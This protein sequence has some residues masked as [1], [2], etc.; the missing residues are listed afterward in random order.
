MSFHR[1][2]LIY[3]PTEI[4]APITF[5]FHT[6]IDADKYRKGDRLTFVYGN[7]TFD[8]VVDRWFEDAGSAEMVLNLV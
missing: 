7:S 5:P 1:M 8:V 6:R 2:L 4:N 3:P